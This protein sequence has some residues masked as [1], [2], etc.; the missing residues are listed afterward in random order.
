MSAGL[1]PATGSGKLYEPS[2]H[3]F[4]SPHYDDVSISCGGTAA[5]LATHDLAPE[6]IVVFSQD[7]GAGSM[8]TF[9]SEQHARWGLTGETV[10]ASRQ[11]EESAAATILGTV[12]TLLPFADAIY[13]GDRYL[14]DEQLFGPTAPDEEHLPARIVEALGLQGSP[15]PDV[16]IYAPLGLGNH[17]DHQHVFRAALDAARRGWQVWFY[18]DLPY[19]LERAVSD[20]RFAA[21]AQRGIAVEIA[22]LVD[23][24][25]TWRRKIDAIMC[26]ASQLDVI[27]RH[28]VASANRDEIDQ[29]MRSY[30]VSLPSGTS[31][32]ERYW[33]LR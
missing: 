33:E 19:G 9:A 28:V 22:A 14:D 13:R 26:Y 15:N 2:W 31:L 27:F 21:L 3:R 25:A 32:I 24:S 29:A 20:A 5:L 1:A 6:T 16:R 30:A 18:E 8:T 7:D 23:V 17:V 4:L 10:G 12:V 11:R